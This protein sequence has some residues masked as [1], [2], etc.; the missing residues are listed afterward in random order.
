MPKVKKAKQVKVDTSCAEVSKFTTRKTDMRRISTNIVKF[1][2][3]YSQSKFWQKA[4]ISFGLGVIMALISVLFAESTGLYVGGFAAF[5]QGTARFTRTCL[6]NW[7][8]QGLDFTARSNVVTPIYTAMFWG[9]YILLNVGLGIF[10]YKKIGKQFAILSMIYLVTLQGLGFIFSTFCPALEHLNMLG[11]TATV[12]TEL[13]KY[14]VKMLLFYPNVFPT[15]NASGS[16]DWTQL[17][18]RGAEGLPTSTVHAVE[19][20][21]LTRIFLLCV[22]ALVFS[23]L[24]GLCGALLFITGSSTAGSDFVSVYISQEKNKPVEKILLIINV[25]GLLAGITL[26]SY[27]SAAIINPAYYSDWQYFFSGNLLCSFIWAVIYSL[28]LNKFFPWRKLT[29]VEIYTANYEQLREHL[30]KIGYTHPATVYTAEGAYLRKETK[31]MVSV[32]QLVEIPKL[33]SIIRS[34]D[35]NCMITAQYIND[36]DGNMAILKQTQ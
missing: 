11:D 28:V 17:I 2:K 31:V 36:Y 32:C 9:Q 26:G 14:D 6:M 35:K 29:K 33:V 18:R 30:I 15:V 3:F 10:A 5:F 1:S 25:S 21:N 8:W 22:Y 24:N 7:C 16:F 4:L 27:A 12:N 20:A 34:I 19:S 13:A 23:V